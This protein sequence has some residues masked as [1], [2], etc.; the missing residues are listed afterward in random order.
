ML[1]QAVVD[2]RVAG[3]LVPRQEH[4]QQQGD[5]GDGG[6]LLVGGQVAPGGPDPARG[7]VRAAALGLPARP[8]RGARVVRR[9]RAGLAAHAG[10]PDAARR[11]PRRTLGVGVRH[12]PQLTL[13][14][15]PPVLRRPLAARA[16]GRP[17]ASPR[18]PTPPRRG[19]PRAPSRSA[20]GRCPGSPACR[21][22][23][24]CG[25]RTA[26]R[27]SA[28]CRRSGRPGSGRRRSGRRAP[29]RAPGC[30]AAPSSRSAGSRARAWRR[31]SR[32]SPSGSTSSAPAPSCAALYAPPL[33]IP[34]PP[35][36][37]SP[38]PGR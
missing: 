30:A 38:R 3:L 23:P 29:S 27:R 34:L 19:P 4:R 28:R 16:R 11:R 25:P 8:L 20:T 37:R 33:R 6:E 24:A 32:A 26:R 18:A 15:E 5:G 7:P 31:S 1:T 14:G 13:E 35:V 17:S 2:E 9:G 21:A 36:R 22:R 10:A 12:G